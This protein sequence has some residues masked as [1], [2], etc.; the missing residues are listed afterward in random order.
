MSKKSVLA[1]AAFLVLPAAAQ[2]QSLFDSTIQTYPGVYVGVE[3]GLNW[4]LNNNSYN[5]NTGWAVG[6]KVGYDFVGPRVELEGLYHSNNGSGVRG[7]PNGYAYIN[8]QIQQVSV[9]ANVLYDFFPA[10]VITPYVGAGAG[11]AFVDDSIQACNLCSTQ[12]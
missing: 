4:L 8:G 6:G 10:S 1:A 5:M 7:F 9:M 12:F 2:A 3:G 11:I